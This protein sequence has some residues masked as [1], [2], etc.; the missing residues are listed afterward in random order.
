[1]QLIKARATAK[2]I[3]SRNDVRKDEDDEDGLTGTVVAGVKGVVLVAVA[4][5]F[6]LVVAGVVGD[7]ALEVEEGATGAT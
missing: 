7:E 4:I 6:E 2:L 3:E 1:M 5:T